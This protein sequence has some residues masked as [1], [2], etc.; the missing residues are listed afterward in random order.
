MAVTKADVADNLATFLITDTDADTTA[1]ANVTGNTSGNIY[2][3][4]GDNSKNQLASYVKIADNSSATSSSTVPDFVFYFPTG[5][6]VSYIVG[7]GHAYSSG[8]SFWGTS[9]VAS[10]SSQTEPA[11]LFTVRILAT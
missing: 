7:D 6:A 9:T 11:S 3:V 1:E 4:Y 5:R 2:C 10:G 8:V